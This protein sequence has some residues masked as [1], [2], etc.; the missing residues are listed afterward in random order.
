MESVLNLM[1]SL[2]PRHHPIEFE[3]FVRSSLQPSFDS[4]SH[5]KCM[6]SVHTMELLN[7]KLNQEKKF[8][9]DVLNAFG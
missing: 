1:K 3:G 2:Y 7:A 8:T 4:Y 5:S 6:L 9:L